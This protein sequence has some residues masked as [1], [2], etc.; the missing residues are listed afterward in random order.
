MLTLRELSEADEAAFLEGLKEW[1]GEELSWYTFDWKPG[2]SFGDHLLALKRNREGVGLPGGR[3]ASTM[4]YGFVSGAIVG[5]LH[6]RHELNPRLLHRGGHIGYAVAPRFRKKGFASEMVR[7]VIPRLRE[8]GITRALVTC[9]DGNE[10]SW[11]II[12]SLGGQL[13]NKVWDE[14]DEETIRRYWLAL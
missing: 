5:R 13:E 3:V 12:E 11:R 7:Q 10:P 4:F 6:V 1:E 8:L 2:I 9:S 14:E